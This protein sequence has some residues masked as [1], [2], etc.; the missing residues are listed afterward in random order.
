MTVSVSFIEIISMVNPARRNKSTV[1]R[2][3]QVS[4]PSAIKIA[5]FILI[6]PINSLLHFQ[7]MINI[8]HLQGFALSFILYFIY[9]YNIEKPQFLRHLL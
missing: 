3:S 5:H 2:P 7:L 1:I 6:S 9:V 8:I 4:N